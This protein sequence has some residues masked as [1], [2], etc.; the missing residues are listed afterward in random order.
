MRL[1]V[2]KQLKMPLLACMFLL[3][4]ILHAKAQ[5]NHPGILLNAADLARIKELANSGRQPFVAG[6]GIL[7][8]N[9]DPN[10]VPGI[11]YEDVYRHEGGVTS[12]ASRALSSQSQIAYR[13]AIMWVIT[14]DMRYA[15]IAKTIINNWA[16]TLETFSGSAAKLCAAWYGFGLVNAAEIIKHTHAG[17]SNA[18]ILRAEAMFRDKFYPVIENFQRGH[19]GNWDTA[20]TKTI[21][22]I[23][24]FLDDAGIYTKGFNFL[25]STTDTANG[26]LNN[27][28]FATTGQC[29]ESGRDQRH[30]QMGIGGLAEACEIGYKQGADLYG[31]HSNRLLLGA[32]YTAKYNL[33]Y[34]VPYTPNYYGNVI[35]DTYRGE[36]LPY[37]EL[38][39]NH[40]VNRK[41]MSGTPIQY[42]KMVVD[43]IRA[44][45]GGENGDA[46][47]LGYGTFL[48]NQDAPF[49][50]IPVEGDYRT[51]LVSS[52]LGTP[53]QFEVYTSGGNWITATTA[54][55]LTT[56]LLIR[57]GHSALASGARSLADLA[58]GEGYGAILS[59]VITGGAVSA[60]NIIAPGRLS[61]IPSLYFA[62]GGQAAGS[63][64]AVAAISSVNVTGADIKN[65]GSG[66]TSATTVS[67]SGGGGSGATAKALIVG[68]KIRGITITNPGS[69][70]TSIP[71]MSITGSGTG[72]IVSA[73]VGVTEVT[74]SSGGSG[75]TIAPKVI[76][77]TFLKVNDGIAVTVAEGVSFQKGSS[78]YTEG[79]TG[80]LNIRRGNLTAEDD[81][82]FVT[83]SNASTSSLTTNFGSTSVSTINT[84]KGTKFTLG[85]LG[86][87]GT[88]ILKIAAGTVMNTAG[89]ITVN[90]TSK[91]DATE[92]IIGFVNFS[93]FASTAK[94]IANN[95][96][97]T[98]IVKKMIV[99][100]T[101]GVTLAQNLVVAELDMQEGVLKIPATSTSVLRVSKVLGGNDNSYINTL[102]ATTGA[103][104]KV[105]L[106]GLTAQAKIPLGNAGSYLPITITPQSSSDYEVSVM[107]GLTQNGQPNGTVV[108]DKSKFVDAVYHLKR[109]SGTGDF[110]VRLT[111]PA[112]LKGSGFSV[113]G[114][115]FG[116]AGYN[117][118]NWTAVT[119][120]GN[121]TENYATTTFNTNSAGVYRVEIDEALPL[122]FL[123]VEIKAKDNFRRAEVSWPTLPM[124][125]VSSD[126]G[127]EISKG[128]TILLTATGGS[129]YVWADADGIV[130]GKNTAVLEVRPTQTTTYSVT[131]THASGCT[132]RKAIKLIVLEDFVKI[133][134][135]NI[136]SP[137]GDGVND[138]WVIDNI[139]LYPNNEVRVFD[140][141]G[142]F[143]YGKKGYD[144]SWEGTLN[145]A[146]LAEGSY[147]YIIDFGTGK[148]P[149]RG[150]ITITRPE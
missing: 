79:G 84:I 44:E 139:D 91:I 131:A 61:S 138:K 92:G 77:G 125:S 87:E 16:D 62:N 6:Y 120:S 24:I 99:N 128:E 22:G 119:G 147:Y 54:L 145:G 83:V 124:V 116:V 59:A 15:T 112:S 53:S 97:K 133:K 56:N 110:T 102:S 71:T 17:W 39:Y 19:A 107:K 37:Y 52:S 80:I 68:G 114:V 90:S 146:P 67:F 115:A 103:M 73:K 45:N 137:N 31:L 63:V 149:F 101:A 113:P 82:N 1:T 122:N 129:S 123:N 142:H 69:G 105:I 27:Y 136:M 51:R 38:I 20:I 81:V 3:M 2:T 50:H 4:C 88:A 144:N 14:G 5:F 70:Y 65:T 41:G 117:G 108:A 86:V 132:E 7:N 29:M 127:T 34:S 75:Y 93:P 76:A 47:L 49:L 85:T 126:K 18:D 36:F 104:S 135:T 140:K 150:F 89:P 30:A 8:T 12:P 130:S 9:T 32:E 111:F 33:G 35:S 141:V 121:N 98:A 94:T 74:L 95:T 96:F 48:F 25:R 42:T 46:I 72:A 13:S 58:V 28:I 106:T 57:D 64:S 143:I 40:Y 43:K 118:T 11:A 26:T 10:Y 109:T 21:M 66:Y 23:G 100:S 134:A 78:V 60:L 148:P 55:G